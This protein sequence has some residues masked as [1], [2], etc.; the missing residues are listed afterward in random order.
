MEGFIS[1]ETKDDLI[2]YYITLVEPSDGRKPY[3]YHTPT[4]RSS[5]AFCGVRSSG[6]GLKISLGLFL[7]L[8]GL[9]FKPLL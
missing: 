8:R 3:K 5:I 7:S 1:K 9:I 4:L 6:R 2:P